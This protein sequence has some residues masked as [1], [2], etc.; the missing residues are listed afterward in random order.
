MN[1]N[2]AK[3]PRFPL[4]CVRHS[5]KFG[6]FHRVAKISLRQFAENS[7]SLF[8]FVRLRAA[9]QSHYEDAKREHLPFPRVIVICLLRALAI[10]AA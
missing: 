4:Q 7:S 3:P 9:L 2:A 1:T 10:R 5:R 6:A 8:R